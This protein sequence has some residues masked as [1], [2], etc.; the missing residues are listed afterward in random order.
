MNF[1]KLEEFLDHITSWR[2][3]GCDCTIHIGYDEVFRYQ[4]GYAD[5][6]N[7]IPM[8]PDRTYFLYSVGKVITCAAALQLFAKNY[9]ETKP[10]RALTVTAIDLEKEKRVAQLSLFETKSTEKHE[11]NEKLQAAIDQIRGKYGNSS[12]KSATVMTS[13][14]TKKPKQNPF[15]DKPDRF[16]GWDTDM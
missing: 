5:I 16:K 15:G 10:V 4:S 11:K 2:I 1:K 7:K 6:E 13:T 12:V 14:L 9:S 8:T 3:P